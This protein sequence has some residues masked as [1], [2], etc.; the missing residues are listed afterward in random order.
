MVSIVYGVA[1][2]VSLA[3]SV[4]IFGNS[5]NNK[6]LRLSLLFIFEIEKNGRFDVFALME[7]FGIGGHGLSPLFCTSFQNSSVDEL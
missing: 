2:F 4:I 3:L 5:S 1:P 6:Q 7:P